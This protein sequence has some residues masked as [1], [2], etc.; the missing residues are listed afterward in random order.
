MPIFESRE[1]L[2]TRLSA[3]IG[4]RADDEALSFIGDT[5]ETYDHLYGRASSTFTQ[6]DIDNAVNE[7]DS[8]W[9]KRYK[10]AFFSGP[11]TGPANPSQDPPGFNPDSKPNQNIKI[12]DLFG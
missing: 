2:Q 12:S 9:R 11:V 1:T 3:I 10:E 4:D 6:E 7:R 5:L 8:E